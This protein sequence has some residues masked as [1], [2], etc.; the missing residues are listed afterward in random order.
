MPAGSSIVAVSIHFDL[1]AAA[2]KGAQPQASR[3]SGGTPITHRT[4]LL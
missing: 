2:M 1:C 4:V 3:E